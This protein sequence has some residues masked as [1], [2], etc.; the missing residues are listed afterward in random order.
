M[1]SSEEFS[2]P[3][4]YTI[5][6]YAAL[7]M[8]E[9]NSGTD[10]ARMHRLLGELP[11]IGR[12]HFLGALYDDREGFSILFPD[13]SCDNPRFSSV[14]HGGKLAIGMEREETDK[15]LARM[16]GILWSVEDGKRDSGIIYGTSRALIHPL[17]S[18]E[19]LKSA[20]EYG[21]KPDELSLS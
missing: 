17:H 20:K 3:L 13:F 2:R 5:T 6:E 4:L 9:S 14:A 10:I 16:F 7:D 18:E 8:Y 12:L 21:Y 1:E 15:Y 19:F 11:I